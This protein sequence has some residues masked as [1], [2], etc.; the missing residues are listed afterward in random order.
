[1]NTPLIVPTFYNMAGSAGTGV[2]AHT[3]GTRQPVI[4]DAPTAGDEVLSISLE[5]KTYIPEQRQLGRKVQLNFGDFPTVAGN[6][7]LKNKAQYISNISFNY[8]RTESNLTPNTSAYGDFES[9]S[10]IGQLFDQW[11]I[12]RTDTGQ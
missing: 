4:I 1:Q 2:V 3:I 7:D 8:P 11:Q 9:V 12:S 6:Y 10:S 5:G